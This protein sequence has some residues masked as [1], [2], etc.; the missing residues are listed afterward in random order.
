M[1]TVDGTFPNPIKVNY[2]C[3]A[4]QSQYNQFIILSFNKEEAVISVQALCIN[5]V[6][7]F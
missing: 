2:I 7:S 6:Q 1:P 5:V 3:S 4:T